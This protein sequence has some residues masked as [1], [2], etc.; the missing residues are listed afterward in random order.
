MATLKRELG[1]WQEILSDTRETGLIGA[2]VLSLLCLLFLA[3]T[4]PGLVPPSA[5][6]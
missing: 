3:A 1:E 6:V 2:A 4:V 5:I